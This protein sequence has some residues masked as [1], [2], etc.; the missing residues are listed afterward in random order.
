MALRWLGVALVLAACGGSELGEPPTE[1]GPPAP[2]PCEAPPLGF[3]SWVSGDSVMV[4]KQLHGRIMG[5]I[6][7]AAVIRGAS[8]SAL[9]TTIDFGEEQIEV[10]ADL[11]LCLVHG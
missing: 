10:R 7:Q 2:A 8:V 6:E 11:S 9:P 5:G 1:A 3:V 4:S